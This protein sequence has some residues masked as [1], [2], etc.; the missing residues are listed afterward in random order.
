MVRGRLVPTQDAAIN[1]VMKQMVETFENPDNAEQAFKNMMNNVP[2]DVCEN[3]L[4]ALTNQRNM[5]LKIEAYALVIPQYRTLVDQIT[6]AE[7]AKL[8]LEEAT[9]YYQPGNILDS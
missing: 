9:K 6:V 1:D 4:E 2:A 7:Q 8:Q 5:K 3:M